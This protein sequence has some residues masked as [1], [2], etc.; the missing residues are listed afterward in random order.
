MTPNSNLVDI[1]VQ[2]T[3]PKFHHPMVTRS[4]VDKETNMQTDKQTPLKTSNAIRYATTLGNDQSW[5][6]AEL[7]KADI[8]SVKQHKVINNNESV[9][10]RGQCGTV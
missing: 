5:I 8:Y 10:Y 3:Y 2:C 1:S 9:D 4:E 6:E 7:I